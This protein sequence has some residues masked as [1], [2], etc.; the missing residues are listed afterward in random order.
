MCLFSKL[1]QP[2]LIILPSRSPSHFPSSTLTSAR[3]AYPSSSS[4]STSAAVCSPS[5]IPQLHPPTIHTTPKHSQ[6]Y[7]HLQRRT[8]ASRNT[9]RWDQKTH[10]DILL[11]IFATLTIPPAELQ[12]VVAGLHAKGYTFSDNAL[13]YDGCLLSCAHLSLTCLF[14]PFPLLVHLP[15]LPLPTLK[16]LQFSSIF[17]DLDRII[18][19]ST[20]IRPPSS[21][22]ILLPA[23]QSPSLRHHGSRPGCYLP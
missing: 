5:Y 23:H 10:E 20:F 22:H 4:P 1:S 19:T 7:Y 16:S 21:I 2:S 15:P 14:P 17:L 9:H 18:S 3:R 13:R 8:M 6:G 12:K 11:E